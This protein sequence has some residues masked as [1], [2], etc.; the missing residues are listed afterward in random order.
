RQFS[1]TPFITSA[2][3]SAET[4]LTTL[5]SVT[6]TPW[7]ITIPLFAL[8]LNL[9]TRLPAVI[10]SRRVAVRRATL[11]LQPLERAYVVR[12]RSELIRDMA[13]EVKTNNGSSHRSSLA[14]L[15]KRKRLLL[16][17]NN[18]ETAR[19][20][21]RWGVQRWKDWVPSLMVFPFWVVGIEALR[22]MCGGP[23]GLLGTFVLGPPKKQPEA[24]GA[25][26][27]G[28]SSGGGVGTGGIEG[29]V[30]ETLASAVSGVGADTSMATGGCLWFPDLMVA[31]PYHVLPLALSAILVMNLVPK[32]QVGLRALLNLDTP[33]EATVA[34]SKWRLRMHRGFLVV[35]TSAGFLTMD[36]PAALHLYWVT[37]AAL[38][39]AQTSIV[40]KLMPLPKQVPPA[41]PKERPIVPP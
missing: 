29:Q 6:A 21:K 25:V 4:V 23:R 20:N 24:D 7:Y 9:F 39:W 10:Y 3:S 13:E 11:Q 5:H 18:Q 16:K 38:T 41:K 27:P 26:A 40:W 30:H 28:G 22:R 19:R 31:D 2:I 33:P 34:T 8:T 1:I 32:S 12:L 35:A 36:L 14:T 37:S 15:D 17:A